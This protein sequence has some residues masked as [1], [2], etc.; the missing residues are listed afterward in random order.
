MKSFYNILVPVDF[1]IK[2]RW[3]ILKAIELANNFNCNIHLVHVYSKPLFRLGRLEGMYLLPYE[4]TI[5]LE[6]AAA[7]LE[8]LKENYAHFMKGGKIEISL[9]HGNPKKE[10]SRYIEQFEMDLVV[11]GMPAF[12]FYHNLFSSFSASMI[13]SRTNVPVLAVRSGGIVSHFKKIV[14]PVNKELPDSRI[15]LATL[16]AQSFHSTIY[17]AVMRKDIEKGDKILNRALH[18]VQSVSS[19]P[20]QCF[21]LEGQSLAKSTLRF[22]KRIKADI[23]FSNRN[24]FHIGK[25]WRKLTKSGIAHEAKEHK[26]MTA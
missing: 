6:R 7:K 3:A 25:F 4:T 18:L 20:V 14:L 19:I 12:N 15:Q 5:D 2:T 8:N 13:T 9:L 10:L 1:A 16:L 11:T 26:S 21:M 17:L 22:S 23:V 24:E